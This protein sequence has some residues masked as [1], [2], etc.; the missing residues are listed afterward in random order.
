MTETP[1]TER[2]G[3]SFNNWITLAFCSSVA[4]A[5]ISELL[6]GFDMPKSRQARI[7]ALASPCA[8]AI[9]PIEICCKISLH[10][11]DT[12]P[13]TSPILFVFEDS[14]I[15]GVPVEADELHKRC[16][17]PEQVVDV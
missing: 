15:D 5:K 7:L 10:A 3:F 2:T 16:D 14:F 4:A 17:L 9:F 12:A 8:S 1:E 11:S 13:I 6:S